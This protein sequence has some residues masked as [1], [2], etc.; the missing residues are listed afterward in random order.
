MS[1]TDPIGYHLH[2]S[3]PRSVLPSCFKRARREFGENDESSP[4]ETTKLI[5]KQCFA[6]VQGTESM[7]DDR[8]KSVPFMPGASVDTST[9]A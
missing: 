5:A 7:K 6:F 2:T 8:G 9:E 3:A 4:K 1:V